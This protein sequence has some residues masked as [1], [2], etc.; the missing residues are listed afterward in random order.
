MAGLSKRERS[1]AE[2]YDELIRAWSRQPRKT[3]GDLFNAHETI[4]EQAKGLYDHA[5]LALKKLVRVWKKG[6]R[7]P[8]DA[9]HYLEIEDAF[10][11]QTKAF[12]PGFAH[13]YKL[14][15]KKLVDTE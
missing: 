6:K 10:R 11:G 2:I 12:A 4:R 9:E 15:L 7:V 13:R 14:K 8:V 3:V 5:D 1:V